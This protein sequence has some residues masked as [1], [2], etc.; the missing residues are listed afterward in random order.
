MKIAVATLGNFHAKPFGL[1][2]QVKHMLER[3]L[4]REKRNYNKMYKGKL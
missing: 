3:R 1:E 4:W 2:L